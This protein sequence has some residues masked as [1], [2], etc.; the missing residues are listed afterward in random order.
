VAEPVTERAAERRAVDD[1][2]RQPVRLDAAEAGADPI[3]RGCLRL[4]TDRVRL[5]Q[6]VGQRS[7]R[8]RAGVVGDVT[9]DRATRVDH[10]GLARADLPVRRPAVRLRRVR[11]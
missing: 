8:E 4:E 9:V 1:L 11:P 5:L 3:E 6:L 7:R 2:A 10:D